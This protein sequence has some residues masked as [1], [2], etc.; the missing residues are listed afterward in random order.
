MILVFLLMVPLAFANN[1]GFTQGPQRFELKISHTDLTYS[2]EI[3]KKSV[4]VRACNR[5]IVQSLNSDLLELVR[6][7]V[8]PGKVFFMVDQKQLTFPE[9]SPIVNALINMDLRLI[10]FFRQE[11]LNCGD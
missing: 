4:K 10:T 7:N 3:L 6:K 2:S 9:T 1:F 11:R 5:T 8:G